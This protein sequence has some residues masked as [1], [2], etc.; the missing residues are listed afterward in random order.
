M[1]WTV[2][3]WMGRYGFGLLTLCVSV[4]DEGYDCAALFAFEVSIT[5]WNVGYG[6]E[7][8]KA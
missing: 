8:K 3:L 7:D 4:W 1:R 2:R 5:F 6:V